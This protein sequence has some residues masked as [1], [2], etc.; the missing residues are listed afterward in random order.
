MSTFDTQA[1]L[2]AGYSEQQV[3][4]Y[5]A[6]LHHFDLD[7]A[8]SAGYTHSSI[9]SFLDTRAIPQSKSDIRDVV[10]SDLRPIPKQDTTTPK[11]ADSGQSA[12]L[13]NIPDATQPVR[14]APTWGGPDTTPQSER[15]YYNPEP[16][17]AIRPAPRGNVTLQPAM[18]TDQSVTP[19]QSRTID[20]PATPPESQTAIRPKPVPDASKVPPGSKTSYA[21]N[22]SRGIAQRAANL[23]GGLVRFTGQ[24]I[25]QLGD[26]LDERIPIG[27]I[28]INSSGFYWRPATQE[29]ID[30]R[31]LPDLAKPLEHADFGYQEGTTWD[32]VKNEPLA[33]VL[34]FAM[35]KL[36]V[37]TP[38]MLASLA[39]LPVY[40]TYLAA[41]TGE[42][43]Q[44]RA[45]NDGRD[46]AT[47]EDFIKVA[48][49][50]LAASFLEK[51]GASRLLGLGA[52]DVV[53]SLSEVPE[54]ALK[55]GAVEGGTEAIQES[56]EYTAQT[57]GTET[58]FDLATAG[59]SALM[60]ATAGTPSGG[61][62]GGGV[63]TAQAL[64]ANPVTPSIG[65]QP[66]SEEEITSQVERPV[67]VDEATARVEP[68]VDGQFAVVD[69]QGQPRHTF[70][71][72]DIAEVS[73][74][75]SNNSAEFDQQISQLLES[76]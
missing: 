3:A 13:P 68:T 62:I 55:R 35:E 43:G 5:L 24:T 72:P 76:R 7:E 4:H 29:D 27:V 38:D 44:G 41:R 23:G 64:S 2:A 56:I 11:V 42:M 66:E 45:E 39:R 40:L 16:D 36:L 74:Q 20:Q 12:A 54:A 65:E 32:E 21:S 19:P 18:D 30:R 1:A 59:E 34:P 6:E 28:D 25:D 50:A 22:I 52:D 69:G 58:G 17:P 71:D 9:I 73:A 8:V 51:I 70:S 60:G 31:V 48:P 33:N 53:R 14:P 37:S 57:L 47:I 63:A 10:S 26:W 67:P 61:I 49:A 15:T 46:Y 75:I